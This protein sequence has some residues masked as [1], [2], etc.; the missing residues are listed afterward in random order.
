MGEAGDPR[1]E[2]TLDALSGLVC[3]RQCVLQDGADEVGDGDSQVLGKP[4][5][6]FLEHGGDAR[7]DDP[8]V[9]APGLRGLERSSLGH[10]SHCITK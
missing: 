3:C 4:L 9:L 1:A 6:F 10:V 7:M 5:Q 2:F 8:L